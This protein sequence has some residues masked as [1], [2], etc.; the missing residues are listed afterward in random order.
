MP[1]THS[2][3]HV[4][5]EATELGKGELYIIGRLIR[6]CALIEDACHSYLSL[7]TRATPATL[8]ILLGQLGINKKLSLAQNFA[9]IRGA[10]EEARFARLFDTQRL[11]EVLKCRNAAVHGF[12]LGRWPDGKWAF[13]TTTLLGPDTNDHAA[14]AT[15]SF[16]TVDL[17]LYTLWAEEL[18]EQA[19]AEPYIQA[20]RTERRGSPL[21]P[22]RKSQPKRPPSGS[23]QPPPEPSDG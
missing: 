11:T 12:L 20:Q 15:L 3:D 22:S 18:A 21:R 6:A 14:V 23:P 5:L 2:S 10:E 19:S 7:V 1:I 8:T 13:E 16:S 4:E 9:K 17:R